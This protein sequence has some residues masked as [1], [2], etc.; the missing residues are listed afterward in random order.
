MYFNHRGTSGL[1]AATY[2]Q[3]TETVSYLNDETSVSV[4]NYHA[5]ELW[6]WNR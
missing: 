6:Y 5:I 2:L 1:K 3:L 4:D